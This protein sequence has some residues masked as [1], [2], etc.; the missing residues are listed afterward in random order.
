MSSFPVNPHRL[1]PYKIAKFQV[2]L[3]GRPVPG[4]ARISGLRRVTDVITFRDGAFPSHSLTAPGNTSF[5]PIVIERGITHDAT[6]EEWAEQ[7]YSAQG[8]GAMSLR[9]FRKDLRINLLNQQ[10][11]V[12]SSYMVYRA[13]V[14]KYQALPELDANANAVAIESIELEYEGFERDR[15]VSEPEEH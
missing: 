6:F 5:E 14:S 13:W 4:V 12:V 15:S 1:D 2:I 10:G 11:N 8:D 9:D 3:E 7:A